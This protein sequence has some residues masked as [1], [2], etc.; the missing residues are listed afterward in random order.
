MTLRTAGKQYEIGD[1]LYGVPHHVCPTVAL[2][3][4]ACVVE[5]NSVTD[6]WINN[7]RNRKIT[8]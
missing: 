3:E 2:H 6:Y 7:S 1:V 5:N 8:V 4:R